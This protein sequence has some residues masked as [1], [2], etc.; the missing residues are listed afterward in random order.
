[1]QNIPSFRTILKKNYL[2]KY[3]FF[4]NKLNFFSKFLITFNETVKCLFNRC[5][6]SI[7]HKSKFEVFVQINIILKSNFNIFKNKKIL[8]CDFFAIHFFLMY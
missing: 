8:F 4:F 1:M 3:L 5:N 2:F 6:T 7:K